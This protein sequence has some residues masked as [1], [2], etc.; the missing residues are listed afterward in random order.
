MKDIG[1]KLKNLTQKVTDSLIEHQVTV[2]LSLILVIV[3][4]S[5]WVSREVSHAREIALA[6]RENVL[7]RSVVSDCE[8]AMKMQNEL[9]N[10]QSD[11]I[12]KYDDTLYRAGEALNDQGKLI[13]DLMNYLKKINHW[14]PKEPRPIPNRSEAMHIEEGNKL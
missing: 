14:P 13:N 11:T 10:L 12:K 5:L 6:K 2:Y 4:S 1:L 8:D 7:L 3:L 9:I